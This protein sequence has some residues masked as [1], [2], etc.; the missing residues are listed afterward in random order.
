MKYITR[1]LNEVWSGGQRGAD[2]GGLAAAHDLGLKTGGY[3]PKGWMTR[4]GP[5]PELEVLGLIEHSSPK[6]PP[7]TFAN[8]KGTD[9]TIRLAT[10]F[11]TAGERLTFEAIQQYEKPFLDIYLLEELSPP[12]V[13]AEWI[14]TN[15]IS[16]LNVA[17]N[18]GET[19]EEATLIFQVVRKYLTLVFS[20][21]VEKELSAYDEEEDSQ[22]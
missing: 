10:D 4:N 7:R 19:R 2:Q 11:S 15:N 5:L 12:E 18:S 14:V 22:S 16:K 6:Y 21:A 9:G 1:V 3:A 20:I 8:V 17:G 13:T